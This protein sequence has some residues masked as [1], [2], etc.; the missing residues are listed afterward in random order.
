MYFSILLTI[1][2][3][4]KLIIYNNSNPDIIFKCQRYNSID[5]LLSDGQVMFNIIYWIY[6]IFFDRS[7]KINDFSGFGLVRRTS[8]Y[9]VSNWIYKISKL[10]FRFPKC[11]KKY[12]YE[13]PFSVY[14]K[15]SML[16]YFGTIPVFIPRYHKNKQYV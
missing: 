1:D 14:L 11:L 8:W 9:S 3:I 4:H 15:C 6:C 10:W 7:R 16:P 5:T 12:F 2:R 13:V